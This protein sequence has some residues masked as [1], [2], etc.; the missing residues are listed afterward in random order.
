MKKTK[1]KL[2]N[3]IVG[4]RVRHRIFGDGIVKKVERVDDPFISVEFNEVD[5]KNSLYQIFQINILNL[6]FH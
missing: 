6:G 4:C 5:V 1:Q 2:L 3:S